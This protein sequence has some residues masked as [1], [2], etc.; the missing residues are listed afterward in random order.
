MR[1]CEKIARFIE[2]EGHK[3]ERASV[4]HAPELSELVFRARG[5][6]YSLAVSEL[7]PDRFSLSTGLRSARVD[8]RSGPCACLAGRPCR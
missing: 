1:V 4:A 7:E 5:Q 2:H 3:V 8:A 6:A